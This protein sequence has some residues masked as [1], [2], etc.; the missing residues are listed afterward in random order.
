ML[1]APVFR[2]SPPEASKASPHLSSHRYVEGSSVRFARAKHG[3][4]VSLHVRLEDQ[5]AA[6]G[7]AI[8]GMLQVL[9]LMRRVEEALMRFRV[10]GLNG[11]TMTA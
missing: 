11:K 10:L 1:E 6:R 9:A 2:R 4:F 5:A 7:R 8:D 3:R